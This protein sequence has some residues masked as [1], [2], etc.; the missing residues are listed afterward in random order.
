[1]KKRVLALVLVM[2]ASF[3]LGACGS[4]EPTVEDVM[5]QSKSVMDNLSKQADERDRE[6]QKLIDKNRVDLDEKIVLKG[7]KADITVKAYSIIQ[8]N[9]FGTENTQMYFIFDYTNK[10][11]KDMFFSNQISLTGYQNGIAL[12]VAPYFDDTA[13]RQIAPQTK[14]ERMEAIVLDSK[15]A[16]VK[17]KIEE[18]GTDNFVEHTIKIK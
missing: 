14:I 5:E 9:T 15:D 10:E 1:M 11:D 7:E 13:T 12:N 4:K 6:R 8:W 16:D 17:L 3:C 2:A 18:H